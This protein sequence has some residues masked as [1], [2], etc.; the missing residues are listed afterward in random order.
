MVRPGDP[1]FGV[2][3][4]QQRKFVD[5]QAELQNLPKGPDPKRFMHP[6]KFHKLRVKAKPSEFSET[7]APPL[8]KPKLRRTGMGGVGESD[9]AN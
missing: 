3:P 1:G 4:S 9:E 5:R 7:S 6:D 2:D 8:P